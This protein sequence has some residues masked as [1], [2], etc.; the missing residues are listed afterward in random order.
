MLLFAIPKQTANINFYVLYSIVLNP[1]LVFNTAQNVQCILS[2]MH[3]LLKID[4][5]WNKKYFREVQ[6]GDTQ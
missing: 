6:N 3:F 4:V 5:Y 2:T 1:Y